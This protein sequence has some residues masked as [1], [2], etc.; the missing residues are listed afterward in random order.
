MRCRRSRRRARR[1]TAS[2]RAARR[3][4]DVPFPARATAPTAGAAGAFGC[5]VRC[6]RRVS[7]RDGVDDPNVIGERDVGLGLLNAARRRAAPDAAR[8]AAERFRCAGCARSSPFRPA[9]RLRRST[10]APESSA[11][12]ARAARPK[13]ASLAPFAPSRLPRQPSS[14]LR[15]QR[16]ADPARDRFAT[17]RL[18]GGRR[19]ARLPRRPSR[20]ADSR[21]K[22]SMRGRLPH[23]SSIASRNIVGLRLCSDRG[24]ISTWPGPDRESETVCPVGIVVA[25]STN[26]VVGLVKVGGTPWPRIG[27]PLPLIFTQT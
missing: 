14:F 22:S 3:R 24:A 26:S 7:M 18:P 4:S 19:P 20:D 25:A 17:L 1:V 16:A 6:R 27:S 8:A 12:R 21:A 13:R 15:F 2:R 5:D 10:R 11:R 23:S 9:S